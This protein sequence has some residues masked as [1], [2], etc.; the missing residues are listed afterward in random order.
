M[1]IPPSQPEPLDPHEGSED[2]PR[3]ELDPRDEHAVIP[4]RRYEVGDPESA[5]QRALE[6]RRAPTVMDRVSSASIP[7]ATLTFFLIGFFTGYW[8]IAWVVFLVPPILKA[9]SRPDHR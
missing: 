8:W 6:P 2:D 7:L 5:A 4:P 1:T 3:R 9:W